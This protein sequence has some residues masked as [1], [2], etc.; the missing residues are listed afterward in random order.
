M[1]CLAPYVGSV[2]VGGRSSGDDY[3]YHRTTKCL[4]TNR[5]ISFSCSGDF[6]TPRRVFVGDFSSC[7]VPPQ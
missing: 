7:T 5:F 2:L 3:D 6:Y 4:Q 1:A